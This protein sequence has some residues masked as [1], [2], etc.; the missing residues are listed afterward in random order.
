MHRGLKSSQNNGIYYAILM[1]SMK[2]VRN[3]NV[4]QCMK[5]S[6]ANLMLGLY[7]V[8]KPILFGV[9]IAILQC[10]LKRSNQIS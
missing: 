10:I 6:T 5:C 2:F 7:P 1:A 9:A 8:V 4:V 3:R